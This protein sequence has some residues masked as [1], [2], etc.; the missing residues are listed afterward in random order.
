[1]KRTFLKPNFLIKAIISCLL[2]SIFH[3]KILAQN[4]NFYPEFQGVRVK[5]LDKKGNFQLVSTKKE[6][7]SSLYLED[8]M[9]ATSVA[10]LKAR[11]EVLRFIEADV[12]GNKRMHPAK[13]VDQINLERQFKMMPL[14]D[15]CY[16]PGQF[17]IVSIEISPSTIE[18][19]D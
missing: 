4:C 16:E 11:I 1:M 12:V 19:A 14:F 3:E 6:K 10:K 9:K 7:V 18:L 2:F 17:V 15:M 5:T 8:V 13:V